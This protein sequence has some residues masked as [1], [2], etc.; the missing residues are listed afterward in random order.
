M[1]DDQTPPPPADDALQSAMEE[2]ARLKDMAARAQADLQNA[3]IRMQKEASDIRIFAVQGLIERLLPT[4]DNFRRA[5]EHLP[6]ELKTHEWVKGVQAMEQ[7]LLR[8]LEA[9][10]LRPIEALGSQVDAS[11][12]E[13]IQTVPG[14]LHMVMQFL[15]SGYELNGKVI[16]PAKVTVGNGEEN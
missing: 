16:K 2:I 15:E 10:G 8:D 4:I 1:S 11:R 6:E 5:F 3:K 13:V 7:Q 14:P 9:A 12:H